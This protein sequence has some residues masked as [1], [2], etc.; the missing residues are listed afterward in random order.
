M[1]C[2]TPANPPKRQSQGRSEVPASLGKR[3]FENHCLQR[4]R[5][6]CSSGAG[7]GGSVP[8]HARNH[9]KSRTP[10]LRCCCSSISEA[11]ASGGKTPPIRRMQQ[12][13]RTRAAR[14]P[15]CRVAWRAA[16]RSERPDCRCQAI[17]AARPTTVVLARRVPSCM[18]RSNRR[19]ATACRG[20][21]S[22]TGLRSRAGRMVAALSGRRV[23]PAAVVCRRR[24]VTSAA[25]LLAAVDRVAVL[26]ASSRRR[27]G[28]T[29]RFVATRSP[30]RSAT[31]PEVRR[32]RR[33]R[34]A[35]VLR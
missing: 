6:R 19:V 1:S 8:G 31:T 14:R 29:A 20:C 33:W 21:R 11:R 10:S 26:S 3:D 2:E 24:F 25:T 22:G 32:F 15:E 27:P 23:G 5:A 18:D 16:V 13:A 35:S 7:A 34:P 30:N 9:S 17:A 12:R 4:D 28:C